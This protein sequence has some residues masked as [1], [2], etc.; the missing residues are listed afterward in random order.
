MKKLLNYQNINSLE[1]KKLKLKSFINSFNFPEPCWDNLPKDFPY[2]EVN[3]LTTQEKHLFDA[4][5]TMWIFQEKENMPKRIAV[6]Y[7]P[8]F[9]SAGTQL[10]GTVIVTASSLVVFM[11]IVSFAYY[12]NIRYN[13]GLKFLIEFFA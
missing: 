1:I 2:C 9:V 13:L 12:L 3:G 11:T 7:K 10:I 4:I 8:T 6:I 5:K